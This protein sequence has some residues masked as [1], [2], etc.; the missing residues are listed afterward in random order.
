MVVR[1]RTVVALG[2][3]SLVVGACSSGPGTRLGTGG[4]SGSAGGSSGAAVGGSGS[5]STVTAVQGG[6]GATVTAVPTRVPPPPAPGS[7]TTAPGSPGPVVTTTTT[8]PPP[9]PGSGVRG[10]VTAGPTCPVERVDNPCPP[11]PV[12]TTLHLLRPDGT[13]AASGRSDQHG[14]FALPAP[15]GQYTLRADYTNPGTGCRPAAVTVPPGA[16]ATANLTCDTGIR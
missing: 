13:E 2:V 3:L 10:T 7:T 15:A 16:Y 9:P 5:G 6:T 11:A 12:T 1:V 8:L 14:Y 4:P